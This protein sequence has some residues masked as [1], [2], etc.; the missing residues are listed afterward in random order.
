MGKL[1][2]QLQSL[3]S[4]ERFLLVGAI[5]GNPSFTPSRAFRDQLG[6]ALRLQIPEAVFSAMDYPLDWIYASLRIA[7]SSD[8]T[9]VFPNDKGMIKAQPE[10]AD[11]LIAYE[12]D[13]LCHL[14]LI[15]AKGVTGWRRGQMTSKAKRLRGIFG[16]DGAQW[17]GV[18]P[19][20]VLVSSRQPQKLVTAE[21]P[22]WMAPAGRPAWI[23]L[24]IPERL[25][26]VS[27]CNATGKKDRK[28]KYWT[29]TSRG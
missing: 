14:V 6:T 28:G 18:V 24:A 26:S 17:R 1:I 29:V 21:W 9:I 11:F 16:D 5:L 27:R 12:A 2:E 25:E 19:H 23:R 13:G 7:D 10:D 20:F 3:N 22:A 8:A 4:K 15:E